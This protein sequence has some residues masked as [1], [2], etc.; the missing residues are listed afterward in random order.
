MVEFAELCAKTNFSFLEG[1]SRPEEMVEA[2]KALG[3][4]ALAVADR[5]GERLAA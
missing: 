5:N 1:G 2:S 3:H 4:L